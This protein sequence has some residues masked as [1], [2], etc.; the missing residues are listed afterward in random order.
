MADLTTESRSNL[1][2]NLIG[3]EKSDYRGDT[4]TLCQGCGHNSIASQIIAA[5]YEMD[6]Q[7]EN[8]I[9]FSG[10]GCSSKSPAY[11]LGR[12]FGFNG[13][14]GRMPSLATGSMFGD[15]TMLAI[16]VSGDGDTAS[17]GMGQ[18]KH[19]MRRNLPMVYIVENNGVYGLTKGQFSAT[20]ESGLTLKGYGTNPYMP[21]DLAWEALVGNA[22]FVARSFAGD[23]KQ[24]KELIKAA[25]SH[26]G[27]AVLDIISP[28]VT[29]NNTDTSMH[30]YAWGKEHEVALH[31]LSYVP[32]REDIL[33]DYEEGDMIDVTMHDGSTVV[34]KKLEHDYDP[35]NRS[36]A[37]SILEEANTKNWLLTGL[38]YIDTEAPCLLDIFNL[39]D[40]A[41][42]RLKEHQIRPSRESIDKVNAMMF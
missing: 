23:P 1:Q 28:C 18:F 6:I 20:A 40:T 16:G 8:L 41:L 11:F 3:L 4:T 12:S 38:I 27:I 21:I 10:I 37:L 15:H 24:V 19:V 29:F 35:T 30:S 14:H 9:K 2:V 33:V 39:T 5:C 32:E 36:H 7:P 25:L 31:E 42:N 13:L 26:R 34:L 17:I 22:T